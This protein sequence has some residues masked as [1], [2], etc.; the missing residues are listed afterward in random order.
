MIALFR[1]YRV[2][3]S[4]MSQPVLWVIHTNKC[5]IVQLLGHYTVPYEIYPLVNCPCYLMYFHVN[6]RNLCAEIVER[7][8]SIFAVLPE[9]YMSFL[10]HPSATN[11]LCSH[12][13]SLPD[14]SYEHTIT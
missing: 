6:L 2:D 12:H 1:E 7:R 13:A 9:Q 8:D 14:G 4:N 3:V 5:G 11:N 10:A